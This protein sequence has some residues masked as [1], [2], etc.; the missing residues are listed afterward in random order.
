[1]NDIDEHTSK[2]ITFLDN[3]RPF[4]RSESLHEVAK[5]VRAL[6]NAAAVG[7]RYHRYHLEDIARIAA[8]ETENR[9]L[10]SQRDDALHELQAVRSHWQVQTADFSDLAREYRRRIKQL[11]AQLTPVAEAPVT[12]A[13]VALDHAHALPECFEKDSTVTWDQVHKLLH[14]LAKK[15]GEK[16]HE[17]THFEHWKGNPR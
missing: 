10:V 9:A 13:H 2:V 14:D 12:E 3:S 1:M 6:R 8:L 15:K 17:P 16:P 7:R 11:E 5:H 4:W